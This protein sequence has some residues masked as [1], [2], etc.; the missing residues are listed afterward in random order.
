MTDQKNTKEKKKVYGL[1]NFC[2]LFFCLQ[3]GIR[4]KP[5]YYFGVHT[6]G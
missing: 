6:Y 5:Y 4:I 3:F 1:V 2:F